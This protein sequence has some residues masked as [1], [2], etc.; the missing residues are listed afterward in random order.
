MV[1]A[2]F[3]S[4]TGTTT[5]TVTNATL[6][7]ISVSPNSAIV[8]LGGSVLFNAIG[9]FSDGSTQTL[10]YESWS[11]SNSNVAIVTNFGLATSSGATGTATISATLN[12]V[13]GTGVMTVQ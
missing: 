3:G 8:S 13:T 12:G 11:S 10:I 4:I 6:Q 2:T 1:T 9:H 7:S 5:V